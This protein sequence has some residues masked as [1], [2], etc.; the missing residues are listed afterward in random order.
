LLIDDQEMSAMSYPLL[1]TQQSLTTELKA[2]GFEVTIVV[3][4]SELAYLAPIQFGE[5]DH[6]VFFGNLADAAAWLMQTKI[7]AAA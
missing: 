1:K 7:I 5:I 6:R 2:L 3:P 4:D